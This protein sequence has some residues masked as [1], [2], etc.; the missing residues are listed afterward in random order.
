[1]QKCFLANLGSDMREFQD[2]HTHRDRSRNFT[3]RK[4]RISGMTSN[5]RVGRS[6]ACSELPKESEGGGDVRVGKGFLDEAISECVCG[7]V[8]FLSLKK[9]FRNIICIAAVLLSFFT[10]P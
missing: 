2:L 4:Q 7:A 5:G 8:D 6:G 10:K 1:M 3:G 9:G